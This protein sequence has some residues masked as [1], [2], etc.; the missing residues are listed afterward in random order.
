MSDDNDWKIPGLSRRAFGLFRCIRTRGGSMRIEPLRSASRLDDGQLVETLNE[1]Q[2]RCWIRFKW[3]KRPEHTDADESRPM[4]DIERV[5]TTR[6]GR[7]RF[8]VSSPAD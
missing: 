2:A 7:F 5:T 3:R 6:F 4:R 1:L 8:E